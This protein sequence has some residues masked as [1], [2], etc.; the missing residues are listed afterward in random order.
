MNH[1]ILFPFYNIHS[2]LVKTALGMKDTRSI[3]RFFRRAEIK[4]HEIGGKRCVLCEDLL[5]VTKPKPQVFQ[6]EP[7]SNFSREIDDLF[8]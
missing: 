1:I 7:Q 8:K 5:A 4:I 3:E 2:D 6:Y